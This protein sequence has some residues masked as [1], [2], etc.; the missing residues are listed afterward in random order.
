MESGNNRSD[1]PAVERL[2]DDRRRASR[3][4]AILGGLGKGTVALAALSPLASQ[5]SRTHK[6]FNP[7]FGTGGADCYC[8]VSGFQ[9]AA[10][11]QIPSTT[12]GTFTPQHFLK[13][14]AL[15]LNYI[16]QTNSTEQKNY[17]STSITNGNGPRDLAISL[18]K[19]FG[20]AAGTI[21]TLQADNFLN[22]ASHPAITTT[23]GDQVLV[24]WVTSSTCTV[25]QGQ[26]FGT[27]NAL[28]AFN[29]LFSNS[30]DTRNL[31]YVLNDSTTAKRYFLA[32]YLSIGKSGIS[33]PADLTRAYIKANYTDTVANNLSSNESLF[34]KAI[35]SIA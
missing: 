26:N 9:S 17:N 13:K 15:A 14:A 4:A 22:S 6:L 33:L 29:T 32:C 20:L 35:S 10:I 24:V 7:N 28:A 3:R 21:T 1:G 30:V 18:N 31:L 23:S 25:Y 8:T 2:E 34:F 27:D 5:A 12:C 19:Y 16:D 11:S